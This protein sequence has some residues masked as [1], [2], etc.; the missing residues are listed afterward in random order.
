MV[1]EKI[2]SIIKKMEKTTYPKG[3]AMK[4]QTRKYYT[5]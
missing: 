2:F 1:E 4:K 5:N 3:K